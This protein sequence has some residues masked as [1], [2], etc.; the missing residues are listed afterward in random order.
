MKV[1]AV[2]I[3]KFNAKQLTVD[4]Q[5]PAIE[6]SSEW[7]EGAAAPQEFR[8]QVRYGTLKVSILFRGSG[9]NEIIRDVSEFLSLLTGRSILQLDGYKGMYIGDLTSNS[10][11]KTRAATRYILTLQLKGYLADAE[12]VNVY[13]GALGVKFTTL[14]TRDAPCIIEILPQT[15]LRQYTISGFGESDIVLTGLERGRAVIIDGEK[16]TVTQ[17]GVNKFADCDIWE[18][19]VLKTGRENVLTFSSSQCDVTVR[20]KPMWL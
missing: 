13:E 1:N 11:E 4:L 19:P 17:D 14:G 10:L 12:V 8:T 2:D 5:P 18:F 3:R 7:V 9:R 16:G 15:S 6:V 20:Y